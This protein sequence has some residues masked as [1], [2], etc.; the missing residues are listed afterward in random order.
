[1][2]NNLIDWREN[3]KIVQFKNGAYGIRK[4]SLM[5]FT[6]VYRDLKSGHWWRLDSRWI[7]DCEGSLENVQKIFDDLTDKGNPIQI[8]KI[9]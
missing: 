6:F 8:K 3:M 1:M 4:W 9:F 2:N 5:Y 7:N